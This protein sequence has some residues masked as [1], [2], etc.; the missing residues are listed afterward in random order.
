MPLTLS[1]L[2]T[3]YSTHTHSCAFPYYGIQFA[4][5][6]PATGAESTDIV[7][8]GVLAIKAIWPSITRTVYDDHER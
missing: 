8:E 4:V 2:P 1:L 6:D 7:C 5:L 3:P